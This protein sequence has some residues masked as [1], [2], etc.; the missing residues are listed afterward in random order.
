M[1]LN[2]QFLK[3]ALYDALVQCQELV[4][5]VG[6]NEIDIATGQPKITIHEEQPK[7]LS[8]VRGI[9]F[10]IVNSDPFYRGWPTSG[11]HKSTILIWGFAENSLAAGYI[12]DML[13]CH[14]TSGGTK[15]YLD[16]TN[17]CI[18]NKHTKY[19]R[20]T[21]SG[22]D[23]VIQDDDTDSYMAGIEV[24]IIWTEFNCN[25]EKCEAEIPKLCVEKSPLEI[26]ECNPCNQTVNNGR[27]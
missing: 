24:E 3:S 21:R 2:Q 9:V 7:F 1:G 26:P 17:D 27:Q 11:V 25:G 23:S 5:F 13:Q 19:V 6:H 22:R 14:F 20:R 4:D 10:E 16:L 18:T 15:G 8:G 12:V